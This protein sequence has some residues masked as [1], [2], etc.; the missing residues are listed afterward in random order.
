MAWRRYA[1][2]AV[3]GFLGGMLLI[4]LLA[5]PV[6]AQSGV[7]SLWAI[8][9][10]GGSTPLAPPTTALYTNPAHLMTG[11]PASTVEVRLF[12]FRGYL[13]GDLLQFDP[14]RD[15][16][17]ERAG[18][19]T[20]AEESDLL[21]TWFGGGRRS[22][23]TYAE[24][25]PVTVAYRPEGRQWGVGF[26]LR[27]RAISKVEADR[28]LFDLLLVG[29]D[30]TRTVPLNGRYRAYST[31]DVTGTFSYAFES[32]PL[33]VGA[34]P[35]LVFGT[36]YADARLDSRA[37]VADSAL[38]HIFDYTARAAGAASREAYNT[39]NAFAASPLE[40]VSADG[41]G[42][43]LVGV[44]TAIDL[45]ATY[46]VRPDLFVSMSLTDLGLVRWNG[47]AQTVTP[48]N[49][50]FRF[51]G[52]ELNV[53]RLQNEFDGDIGEYF[54]SQVDSLARAAY[55][56]VQRDR[57]SFSAGLPTALHA[58]GTWTR[59]QYTVTGGATVGLNSTAGAVNPAPAVH[60]G[61]EVQLG[62]VPIRAG[63]RLGGPQAVT[64]AGGVGLDLGVY[65]FDLSVSA[66]PSTSMLGGG[67]RYAIGLSL[68]T[69]RF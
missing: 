68:A 17:G 44:G 14:Y 59:S 49:N 15:A 25:A 46:Q 5:G 43:E 13:G 24:A 8:G 4:G 23:A 3:G 42:T 9:T 41:A 69:I 22:V 62:P 58:S 51:D 19:L 18:M 36:S 50:E 64:L 32:L 61:G 57:S 38:V 27:A 52:V 53:D 20:N 67:A 33:W 31:L 7:R 55:E 56:D 34:S 6:R 12:D 66:T 65:R 11:T 48:E 45:G 21:D 16:F 40:D 28:G 63:L 30:S 26:G 1:L 35:R 37:R 47:D 54:R 29:A 39:F 60:A 2:R 10:G